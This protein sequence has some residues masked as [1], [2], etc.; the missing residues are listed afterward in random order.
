MFDAKQFVTD[1]EH[2]IGDLVRRIAATDKD[3]ADL[4][5]CT[6]GIVRAKD[7]LSELVGGTG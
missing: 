3:G 2:E 6:G 7:Y 5:G 1:Y 4:G